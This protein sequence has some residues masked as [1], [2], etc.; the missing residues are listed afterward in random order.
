M[1]NELSTQIASHTRLNLLLTVVR[2]ANPVN[3]GKN[4]NEWSINGVGRKVSHSFG[5]GLM[6]AA[7][8]VRVARVWEPVPEQQRCEIHSP[9]LDK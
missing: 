5:Y 9:H 2:T 4:A 8:M 7:A 1:I 3:L 6:D